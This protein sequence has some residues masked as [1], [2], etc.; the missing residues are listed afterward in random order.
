MKKNYIYILQKRNIPK[1]IKI[2]VTDDIDKRLKNIQTGNSSEIIVY[3][4]E[5]RED[6]YK[7]EKK[8][9]NFFDK[10]RLEK[11]EWFLIDP[12]IVRKKIFQIH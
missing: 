3:Y 7:V 12:K 10:Y 2:G 6:A 11:G 5:E 8:L 4:I 9:H 1:E